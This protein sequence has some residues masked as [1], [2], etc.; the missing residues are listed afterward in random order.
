[1][2]FVWY[3]CCCPSLVVYNKYE[4]VLQA[5]VERRG[6][7]QTRANTPN[8]CKRA[9]SPAKKSSQPYRIPRLPTLL[10]L[11]L[12]LLLLLLFLLLL[13]LLFLLLLLLLLLLLY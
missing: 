8:T 1:M 9:P 6:N 2:K 11:L 5:E 4:L 10:L 13:L 12:P 7:A 3:W